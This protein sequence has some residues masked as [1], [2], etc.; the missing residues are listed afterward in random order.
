MA[1]SLLPAG[2]ADL[3]FRTEVARLRAAERRRSFPL[4]VHVGAPDGPRSGLALP[5]PVP[6]EYDAGL[7][8]D[9]ADALVDDLLGQGHDRPAG[10]Q[11]HDGRAEQPVWGWLTR[12]GVP[13][14]H[15]RDLEWLSAVTR[16]V[17]AHG[18]PIA[19]FRAVTRTGWL[20]VVSGRSRTWRRLRS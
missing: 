12:P 20:D 11:A 9:L 10:H 17:G 16:A 18:L 19:G 3:A 6:P 5:W 4:G 1:P 13:R 14:V 15:D 2:P 8:F 7:R